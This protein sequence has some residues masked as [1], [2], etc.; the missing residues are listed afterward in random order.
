M[1]AANWK[2]RRIDAA[3]NAQRQRPVI[4]QPRSDDE[5]LDHVAERRWVVGFVALLVGISLAT[6]FLVR[7]AAA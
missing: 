6:Y 1:P 3:P 5:Y 7:W 2:D 4:P